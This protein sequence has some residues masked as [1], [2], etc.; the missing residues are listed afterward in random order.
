MFNDDKYDEIE[1]IIMLT[2]GIIGTV[3]FFHFM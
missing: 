3:L 1:S 2:I